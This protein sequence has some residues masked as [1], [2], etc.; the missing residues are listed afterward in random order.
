M[1][2]LLYTYCE[3]KNGT[4]AFQKTAAKEIKNL[5]LSPLS[6]TVFKKLLF[7]SPPNQR[8]IN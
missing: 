8:I 1:K 3:R 4:P 7:L 5:E 2:N 6:Y